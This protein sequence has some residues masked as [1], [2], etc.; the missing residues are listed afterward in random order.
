[1]QIDFLYQAI[2]YNNNLDVYT[3]ERNGQYGVVS[4]SGKIIVDISYRD[5]YYNGIYILAK[6]YTEDTYFNKKGEKIES[7][8]TSMTEVK[9]TNSYVTINKEDRYGIANQN[10]EETVKNEYLYIEHVFDN[11][12]VAYKEGLG[13]GAID[14]D[15]NVLIDFKYDVLSPVLQGKLLEAID[16]K[17][18]ITEIYSRNMEK[19]VSMQSATIEE[20]R[21]YIKIYND[22][23]TKFVTLSAEVKTAKD[24]LDNKLYA[25]YK[26]GKWGY[27]DKAGVEKISPEYDLATEFNLAGF[28]GVRKNGKWGVID[29]DRKYRMRLCI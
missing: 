15:G 26:D 24:V 19:L 7:N 14:K 2:T 3:V 21:E 18:N 17:N 23:E 29:S 1:M 4:G 27:T 11:C 5:I 12:F 16:L 25:I 22:T 9:E 28:A 8:Y 10:G 20:E 6:S 13:L